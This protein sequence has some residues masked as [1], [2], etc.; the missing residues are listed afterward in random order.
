MKVY[1]TKSQINTILRNLTKLDDVNVEVFDNWKRDKVNDRKC[2]KIRKRLHEALYKH[3]RN[4][5]K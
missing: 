3:R 1:L 2:D 4:K 5:R